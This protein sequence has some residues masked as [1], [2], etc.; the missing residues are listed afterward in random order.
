MVALLALALAVVTLAHF[1][2]LQPPLVMAKPSAEE[3]MD[4][5]GEKQDDD[6]QLANKTRL[7][8]GSR[9][10]DSKEA[11][12]RE[13]NH[14]VVT[15]QTAQA[16]RMLTSSGMQVYMVPIQ[17]AAPA[18]EVNKKHADQ[19]RGKSGH[20]LGSPHVQSWRAFLKNIV[21]QTSSIKP[22]QKDLVQC[23]QGLVTYIADYEAK[24]VSLGYTTISQS[25]VKTTRDPEKAIVMFA[26]ADL[27]EPVMRQQVTVCVH[28]LLLHLKA[29]VRPGTAPA[30]DAERKL[31]TG[32]DSI[33]EKQGM[34]KD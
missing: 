9:V 19:T 21:Y 7:V 33:K 5:T 32:I 15:L 10:S 31:Q 13:M 18:I 28:T 4:L 17:L 3:W 29:E 14:M 6:D 30:T 16:T 27:V 8:S 1:L 26:M 11:L 2:S 23:R 20:K 34:K 24:G 12:L 25:R 22:E